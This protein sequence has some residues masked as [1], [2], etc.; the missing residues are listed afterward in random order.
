M[1]KNILYKGINSGDDVICIN[2][3]KT[4]HI[5]E[6]KSYPILEIWKFQ[7]K[8]YFQIVDDENWINS[9]EASRFISKTDNREKLLNLLL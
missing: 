6:D 9:F 1:N 7:N 2:G 5:T 8:Y 4:L 3:K